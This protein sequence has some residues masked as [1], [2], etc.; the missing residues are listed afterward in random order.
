MSVHI[1]YTASFI[2][3]SDMVQQIQQLKL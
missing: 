1:T 2:E 3:T